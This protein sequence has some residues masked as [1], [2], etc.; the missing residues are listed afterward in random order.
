MS[1]LSEMAALHAAAERFPT[2]VLWLDF[3]RFLAEPVDG[4]TAVLAHFG[5]GDAPA[6]ARTIVAGP[7]M[8]QYAKAPAHRFD[9]ATRRQLLSQSADQHAAEIAKGL[10]WLHRAATDPAVAKVLDISSS[11]TGAP[12]LSEPEA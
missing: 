4:L 8:E 3:D 7:T 6:A 10:A 5:A 12:K 9:A 2:R 11:S 1:W